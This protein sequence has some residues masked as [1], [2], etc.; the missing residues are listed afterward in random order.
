MKVVGRELYLGAALTQIVE[1]TGF[2]S[3]RKASRA[4][5]HYTI[6]E[7]RRLLIRYTKSERGP[8]HFTFRSY[9]LQLIQCELEQ[10]PQ[11]FVGLVCGNQATCLLTATQFFLAERK[12]IRLDR[13]PP[14]RRNLFRADG[15][16]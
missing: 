3:M 14:D 16:K 2:A 4:F 9:D 5:G 15:Q 8:W 12:L 7:N 1:S 6:N 11:F 13:F 10:H